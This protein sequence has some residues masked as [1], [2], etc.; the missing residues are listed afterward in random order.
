MGAD[1][2]K[3]GKALPELNPVRCSR[4][5]PWL[6]LKPFSFDDFECPAIVNT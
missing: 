4:H 1:L 3:M 6:S 5:R 2:I